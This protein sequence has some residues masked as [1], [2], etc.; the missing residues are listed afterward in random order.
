METIEVTNTPNWSY[1]S[2]RTVRG[3][4]FTAYGSRRTVHGV[5]FTGVRFTAY[6]SPAYSSR[7]TVHGVQFTA[8]SSRRT[9]HGVGFTA[10]SSRRTVHGVQFTAYSSPTYDVHCTICI[11]YTLFVQCTVYSVQCTVYSVRCTVSLS[12]R[13]CTVHF[14]AYDIHA[15]SIHY[16]IT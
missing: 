10:Y 3:V 7:R 8:Y 12:R 4:R 1:S 15:H 11:T 16:T 5:Q 2:R 6:S 13:G 14:T 9:V